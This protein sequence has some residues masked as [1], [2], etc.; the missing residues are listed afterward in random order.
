MLDHMSALR[1]FLDAQGTG[2][3]VDSASL[4]A[5]LG[6]VWPTLA[7]GTAE[8][9]EPWKLGRIENCEWLPP[10]LTFVVER[11]LNVGAD[12]TRADLQ[13]WT[14]NLDSSTALP[15]TIGYRQRLSRSV[16]ARVAPLVADVVRLVVNSLDDGRLAW[17]VGRQTVRIAIGAIILDDGPK[18]T[19][20]GRRRR[21]QRLLKSEMA[22]AGWTKTGPATFEHAPTPAG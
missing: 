6:P 11:H 14:V 22:A 4:I 1:T 21:F 9:M 7:G 5:R 19:V 8:S 16:P 12:G 13:T 3:L 10:L 18:K 17:S 2:P 20:A 15:A